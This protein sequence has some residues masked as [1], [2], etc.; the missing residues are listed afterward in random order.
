M[1]ILQASPGEVNGA[2][3]A[4]DAARP[5]YPPDIS[6][7]QTPNLEL[8]FAQL[9]VNHPDA[10]RPSLNQPQAP[11]GQKFGDKALGRI[12]LAADFAARTPGKLTPDALRVVLLEVASDSE[13]PE[14]AALATKAAA[15]INDGKL[16]CPASVT[17]SN[18]RD[19][20]SAAARE[21]FR[22]QG[23]AEKSKPAP[24]S[25]IAQ[26]A[27]KPQAATEEFELNE[28]GNGKR[29]AAHH[30][31]A[32]RYCA[33]REQWQAW[34]ASGRWQPDLSGEA[35]RRAK[36][37]S[38]DV[39]SQAARENDDDRRAR[40]L[41]HAITLTKRATRETMLKDAASEPGMSVTLE[42]FD[43]NPHAFNVANGT[44]DLK[45]L[46][47]GEHRRDDLLTQISFVVFDAAATCPA[48]IVS[49]ERWLPDAA[50]R[51]FVQEAVGLSLLGI[52]LDEFW[53]FLYGDGANGKSTF[54]RVLEWLFGS[55]GHKAQA[56]TFMQTKRDRES[57]R[58]SPELLALKGKRLVTVQE[59][60]QQHRLN[61]TLI[62]D[63][64]GR[65]SITARGIF[66]KAETTF[67]PQFTLWMFGNH[68]PN[69]KDTSAGTWRRVR[70]I[71]F[72]QTIPENERDSQL[73][74]KLRAELPG[75]LNWALEGLRRVQQRGVVVP[76]AVRAATDDYRSEQDA[77]RAFLTECTATGPRC[78]ATAAQLWAAWCAWA[79]Q[80]GEPEG[81]QRSFGLELRRRGFEKHTDRAGV[82]WRGMGILESEE[83]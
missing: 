27:A 72:G 24:P 15:L 73:A 48:W 77:F 2:P 19:V 32:L 75:I 7:L 21:L 64:T 78:E 4:P 53:L 38:R 55:Y 40:L 47:F 11:D 70:L 20:A 9:L 26:I 61:E 5:I 43:T 83:P 37:T 68:R 44:L 63:L 45:T 33:S 46:D 6:A 17:D 49:T 67:M 51:D 82:K 60:A 66:A 36:Q 65:D 18:A 28:I 58:P 35:E 8:L 14:A 39:V 31:D 74:D 62:K 29:F 34:D 30:G 42:A 22:R 59:T 25:Q 56:E 10:I 13:Q 71:P 1:K 69:I 76:E 54:I 12:V 41:K 50:T 81:T 79:K 80:N 3:Q 52:A 23:K 16:Q 57:G